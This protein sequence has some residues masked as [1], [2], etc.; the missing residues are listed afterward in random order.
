MVA[1]PKPGSGERICRKK[2]AVKHMHYHAVYAAVKKWAP[3]FLNELKK[4][5][6]LYTP[7]MARLR[8]QSGRATLITELRGQGLSTSLSM[9]YAQLGF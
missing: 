9:K 3:A 1:T 2:S 5:G 4:Q 7:E 6:S 8:P